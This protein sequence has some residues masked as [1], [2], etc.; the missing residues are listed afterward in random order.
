[1]LTSPLVMAQNYKDTLL[2][3]KTDFPMKAS[4]TIREP[5]ILKSWEEAGLY[6][7]I[8]WKLT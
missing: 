1:M 7:Q 6:E 4:L 3:P 2:L 5:E 8:H